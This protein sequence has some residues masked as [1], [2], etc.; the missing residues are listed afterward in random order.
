MD[1]NKTSSRF[2]WRIQNIN[3]IVKTRSHWFVAKPKLRLFRFGANFIRALFHQI[4]C[5]TFVRS[6]LLIRRLFDVYAPPLKNFVARL[7]KRTRTRAFI[8]YFYDL[9]IKKSESIKYKYKKWRLLFYIIKLLKWK[10]KNDWLNYC[11]WKDNYSD[12]RCLTILKI[13]FTHF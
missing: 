8:I 5:F 4:G 1:K 2:S 6:S 11:F 13:K 9:K 7:L 10:W 12:L 3:G